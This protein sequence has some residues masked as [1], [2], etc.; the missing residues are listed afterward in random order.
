MYMYIYMSN[1]PSLQCNTYV[2][3]QMTIHFYCSLGRN[4]KRL[5]SSLL[6]S[7]VPSLERPEP[8]HGGK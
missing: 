6:T 2:F 4:N 7:S 3:I 1:I 5:A 8:T